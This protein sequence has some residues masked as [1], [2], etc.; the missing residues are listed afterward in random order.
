MAK[1]ALL[2]IGCEELP[3]SYIKPACRQIEDNTKK[4]L[5]EAGLKYESVLTHSTPRRL[6]LYIE[7]LDEKSADKTEEFFGPPV[8]VT[9]ESPAAKGF[10]AKHCVT[11][12]KLL[13]K[14]KEKGVYFCVQK[15]VR[16][17][18]AEDILREMFPAVISKI[19][20]PKSMVWEE[21][22]F[23][24]ARPLR[25]L[26][27]IYSSKIIK[28][29][30]AGVKSSNIT[31]GLHAIS[32]RK[33]RVP[34]PD[35]YVSIM[36]NNLILVNEK[37][38]EETIR[39]TVEAVANKVKGRVIL[40]VELLDEVN[41][42]VEHP[43]AVLGN[44]GSNYLELP[45]VVLINCMKKKQ[46]F[47]AVVDARGKLTN[48]FIGIRNG[49]SENQQV[50][51]EGYERVLTARLSDAEFFFKNDVKT[52][53][54]N[55]YEKLKGVVFQ[56]KLGT[57]HDKMERVKSNAKYIAEVFKKSS[58][59]ELN[60]QDI[61]RACELA[62]SD[63]VS[64]MVFEYPEL[65]GVIGSIYAK[66]NGEKD[67]VAKSVAE[68]YM[69]ITVDGNL[70]DTAMGAVISL[71]DKIDT[72][73]GYFSVGFVPSG[74]QDP[75]ALRRISVGILR[76]L[77]E[78]K[79]NLPLREL[80]AKAFVN[81][82]RGLGENPGAVNQVNEFLRQRLENMVI[83]EGHKV[84]EVRAVLA[85]GF[86]DLSDVDK[87]LAALNKIRTMPDFEPLAGAFKRMANII[88]QAGKNKARIADSVA[89][90]LLKEEAEKNL[91]MAARSMETDVQS[92]VSNGDYFAALQKMVSLKSAV[93][94]FFDKVM[95]MVEDE[96]LRAN[97]LSVLNFT[98]GLFSKIL[99]FSQLQ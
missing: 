50:V 46:K 99:D 45:D 44:F 39:K 32:S 93:D 87:R 17:R 70:P 74:S 30:L 63:L 71:A 14:P 85:S 34:W 52:P 28:F 95:V 36:R 92:F 35:K 67:D 66:L 25:N 43:V 6:V 76:I 47:F 10:A 26:L 11:P 55:K 29:S 54:V 77:R 8:T 81:L 20:F 86:D 90:D 75:Y 24:F 1:N 94:V 89:E 64:E 73:C 2:E 96:P 19:S 7:K 58:G 59:T 60:D 40:D 21:S 3:A 12:D 18:K 78:K 51:K 33:I 79:I 62:K 23:R 69:P 61:D 88:K 97:R 56:E 9:R 65:Q 82:P 57:V 31:S 68:H 27:A 72:L 53:L 4:Y 98:T 5:E 84:D 15:S 49:V 16:G 91:Y 13:E 83:N 37:D 22:K 41:C 38:R 48:Y 80:V 42:L